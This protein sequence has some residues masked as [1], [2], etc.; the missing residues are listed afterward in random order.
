MKITESD[1]SKL[2]ELKQQRI[3]AI[4]QWGQ[5]NP[6]DFNSIMTYFRVVEKITLNQFDIQL[7]YMEK[8][9]A[10]SGSKTNKFMMKTAVAGVGELQ[11]FLMEWRS[12]LKANDEIEIEKKEYAKEP[13]IL[14]LDVRKINSKIANKEFSRFF[15]KQKQPMTMM[16]YQIEFSDTT[17]LVLNSL[18]DPTQ[19]ERFKSNFEK[20]MAELACAEPLSKEETSCS[21]LFTV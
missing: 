2:L 4:R 18:E 14:S 12:Q 1:K 11:E 6:A 15:G 13:R 19:I 7:P 21:Q 10:L 20:K 5:N 17:S 8:L 9:D 3:A 16:F